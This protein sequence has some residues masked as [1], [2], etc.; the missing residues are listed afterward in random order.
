MEAKN[1]P[2]RCRCIRLSDVASFLQWRIT[3]MGAS[4]SRRCFPGCFRVWGSRS[5]PRPHDGQLIG[6]LLLGPRQPMARPVVPADSIVSTKA[7]IS[8]S[9]ADTQP[10]F[11]YC[12]QAGRHQPRG[13]GGALPGASQHGI[14]PGRRDPAALGRPR[15]RRDLRAP[16]TTSSVHEDGVDDRLHRPRDSRGA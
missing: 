2:L 16:R 5:D 13:R 8:S 6:R 3:A 7:V 12:R 4:R 1:T 11:A 9:I 15:A 10:V 14:G